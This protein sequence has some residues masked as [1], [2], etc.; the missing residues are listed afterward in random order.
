MRWRKAF[1]Y[2]RYLRRR[3]KIVPMNERASLFVRCLG[4]NGAM[5]TGPGSALH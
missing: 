2:L 5:T 4:T 3:E 1:R